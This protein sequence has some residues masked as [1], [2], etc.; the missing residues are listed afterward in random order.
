MSLE[1]TVSQ[2]L[3]FY[4]DLNNIRHSRHSCNAIGNCEVHENRPID[5]HTLLTGL[6]EFQYTRVVRKVSGRFEYLFSRFRGLDV[7][8]PP[9]RGDLTAH[10]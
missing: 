4:S 10:P 1:V 9:F 5:S 3:T 6:N 7:T 8:W 2:F